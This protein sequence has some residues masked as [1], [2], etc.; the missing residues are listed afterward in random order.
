LLGE[1]RVH[2]LRVQL[3]LFV[4]DHV[5]AVQADLRPQLDA[6]EVD[7]TPLDD[8]EDAAADAEAGDGEGDLVLYPRSAR[9]LYRGLLAGERL[10]KRPP[11]DHCSRCAQH[12]ELTE[13]VKALTA[14]LLSVAG[15]PEFAAHSAMV[16]R[17]GGPTKAWEEVRAKQLELPD[18]QK[19]VMW[20]DKQRGW[21]KG[22]E[23]TS[24]ET[25][26]LLQLDYG[27]MQD[28]AGKKVNV[29]SAT[30]LA[31]KRKQ[32]HIDF[33]FD[34]ANQA[35]SDNRPG[36]KKNGKTGVYFL[37]ELLDPASS[38]NADGV[39]LFKSLFPK[40]T[41]L[42]L[43]GDTGNGYRAYEMLDELSQTFPTFGYSVKLI[44]LAPGHAWNRTDA[45]IAHMNT[46]LNALKSS[47]RVF[48]AENIAAAFHAASDPKFAKRRKFMARSHVFFRVVPTGTKPKINRNLGAHV[49][50]DDLDGGKM[51]VRG[52]LYFDFSCVDEQGNTTHPAGYARVREHGDPSIRSN[53]TYVYT[54]RRDLAKLMCQSCSDRVV[55]GVLSL[56][57]SYLPPTPHPL[58]VQGGPVNWAGSRC[59]KTRCAEVQNAEEDKDKHPPQAFPLG[60]PGG[61]GSLSPN[62]AV[63]AA[64]PAKKKRA[65]AV[66][67]WCTEREV[68]S[69]IPRST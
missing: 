22:L 51:G 67:T 33:F 46:F 68:T 53:P 36:A 2:E 63:A 62:L 35:K 14:A 37:G 23:P 12:V 1:L 43:S 24:D 16:E 54:W 19:H 47:S 65:R 50:H 29:W 4:V 66:C 61:S 42:I 8:C 25:V 27:G 26:A 6:V 38:P 28:S 5:E 39:S 60:R 11:H 20:R 34:A 48:G 64:V 32:E 44:P 21:L 18:L 30:V 13:R 10:W 9:K 69:H 45:R 55:R 40:V 52:L 3:P 57:P 59:T 58:R 41:H 15:D 17:A 31:A 49:E 56:V 7:T